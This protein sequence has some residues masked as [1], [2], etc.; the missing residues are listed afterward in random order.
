[1]DTTE[2]I[3]EQKLTRNEVVD[4]VLEEMLEHKQ[5]ALAAL[6]ATNPGEPKAEFPVT[7]MVQLLKDADIKPT[8]EADEFYNHKK[9]RHETRYFAI[10]RVQVIK[11]D[12][13]EY[14]AAMEA[15]AEFDGKRGALVQELREFE[16]SSKRLKHQI[17]KGL[18]DNSA[19][20][21]KL[22][23]LVQQTATKLTAPM[24]KALA[25]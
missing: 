1:M 18:L 2:L 24:R 10:A 20:G 22:L 25:K 21:K 4:L 12:A 3:A 17:L 8:I 19:T 7:R 15:K 9:H 11:E 5:A 23:D 14:F 6:D 13:P 16:N